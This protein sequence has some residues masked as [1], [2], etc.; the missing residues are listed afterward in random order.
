MPV[1][2]LKS[3]IEVPVKE[4][5]NWHNRSATF[6]RLTPSWEKIKVL[7]KTGGITDGSKMVFEVKQG[8]FRRRWVA[9]HGD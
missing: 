7:E 8:P 6:R 1:F 4:L 3:R 9:I 2:E 5:F